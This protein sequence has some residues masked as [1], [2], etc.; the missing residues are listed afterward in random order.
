MSALKIVGMSVVL[1]AGVG[2][3]LFGMWV[4]FAGGAR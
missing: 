3:W 2:L 4:A 1:L